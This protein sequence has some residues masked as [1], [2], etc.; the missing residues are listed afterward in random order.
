MIS[1]RQTDSAAKL[2]SLLYH[3]QNVQ[4]QNPQEL[5]AIFPHSNPKQQTNRGKP[6]EWWEFPALS[7]LFFGS[8]ILAS[9][10]KSK[11]AFVRGN[12]LYSIPFGVGTLDIVQDG[13]TR[14]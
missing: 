5:A 13:A 1:P 10:S 7:S 14:K 2:T 9:I 12:Q 4:C 11:F 8:R 3:Q 6:D